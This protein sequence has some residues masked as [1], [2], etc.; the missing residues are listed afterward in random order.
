MDKARVKC[1]LCNY[2]ANSKKE[3]V[4]HFKTGHKLNYCTECND[5]NRFSCYSL[6]EMSSHLIA[7]HDTIKVDTSNPK[8]IEVLFKKRSETGISIPLN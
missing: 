4:K 7:K 2:I 6:E 1:C 5:Q 3:F 8:V